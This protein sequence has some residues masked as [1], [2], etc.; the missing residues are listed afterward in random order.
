MSD[1]FNVPQ[2]VRAAAKRGLELRKEHGRG[3]FDTR[4]ASSAGVGSGVQRASNLIQGSVSYDT[5]KRMLAFFNRHKAYKKHH[6]DKTSA[7]YISWLLW[8]GDAG[9]AWARRI[10]KEQE[11]VKKGTLLA[12]VLFGDDY[13]EDIETRTFT[14]LLKAIKADPLDFEEADLIPA[15]E[16]EEADPASLPPAKAPKDATPA[17]DAPLTEDEVDEY[18]EDLDKGVVVI[19]LLDPD[20]QETLPAPPV[21]PPPPNDIHTLELQLI[22]AIDP[23]IP[24]VQIS[25][26]EHIS[27]K[28]TARAA[29]KSPSADIQAKKLALYIMRGAWEQVDLDLVQSYLSFIDDPAY[30]IN[31]LCV[32]GEAML[33]AID[34]AAPKVPAKYLEG[35]TGEAREARK[36]EIQRR[37]S[38][39]DRGDKYAPIPGDKDAKT[40]PSKYTRSSFA[41]KV[42]DEVS[43]PGKDEFL[44]AAAKVSGISRRILNEVYKR[45][46]EAWATSGHRPGASQEAWARARVY[47]FCTGGKTRKTA[48][49]DLWSEH[50]ET[51]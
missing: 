5:V 10:V 3:G 30:R 47:S 4:Q 8:G 16:G 12:L 15:E 27:I 33:K 22:P 40:K 25:P 35:L 19:D 14:Q 9:Y 51:T 45:G 2:S 28:R 11:K 44:R 13:P 36:R 1:S 49:A 7:A 32:G 23:H 38:G 37:A 46:S 34:K 39:K 6:S 26:L 29:R 42:R 41:A 24:E 17:E 50:N 48:D 18:L 21:P 31:A 20:E 43:K